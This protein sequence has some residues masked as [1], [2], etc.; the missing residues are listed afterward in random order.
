MYTKEQLIEKIKNKAFGN[1][2]KITNC[3]RSW[4]I[5]AIYEDE[6]SVEYYDKLAISKLNHGIKLKEMGRTDEE[7]FSIIN[8]GFNTSITAPSTK[9]VQIQTKPNHPATDLNK[10]TIDIT[11]QT[12][13]LLAESIA[14]KITNEITDKFTDKFK[15]SNVLEPLID[16]AKIK[17]DNEILSKQVERL[18][19]ENKKLITRNNFL[20]AENAK[21]RHTFGIWYI[22]TQ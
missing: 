22:K 20:Q 14:Q 19:E 1:I 21:F 18:L 8:N 17:R 2:E 10:V 16:S 7:I 12:L 13:A 4:H 9:Q 11:S 6:K 3:L 15:E 5:D